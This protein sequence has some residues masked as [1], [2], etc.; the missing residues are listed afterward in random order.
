MDIGWMSQGGMLLDGSG[1]LRTTANSLEEVTSMI[2]TR[3]KAAVDG[4]KLYNIGAGLEVYP[5]MPVN[6][7]TE[8][9]IQRAVSAA[10]TYQFLPV[11]SFSLQTI[12]IGN[13]IELYVYINNTLITSTTLSL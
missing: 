2:D 7:D 8:L 11:G 5:G 3:L 13:Q 1:D 4:W 6:N 9:S 12:A 10:L